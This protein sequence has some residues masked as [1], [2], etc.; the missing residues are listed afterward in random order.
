MYPVV[1]FA[2]E[3][4]I[5]RTAPRLGLF[6]THISQHICWPQD[7]DPWME[8][9][10]GR[11]LTLYDFGRLVLFRRTGV[12]G[13][14]R[15]RRWAGTVAGSS[16]RYRRRVRM[17]HKVE[18][19][20]RMLGWDARFFYIEQSMWRGGECTSNALFRNAVT[21]AQG[22]VPMAEVAQ[23]LGVDPVSP[24]LPDWVTAWSEAEARRPWPPQ[25]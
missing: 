17:F 18:M 15:A 9:N 12:I 23:A 1:R 14:M 2:K 10:N 4:L 13:V 21:S 8:L 6:D 24:P 11:T 3:L 22:M 19:R 20:S 7:I 16:V 25:T 5:H